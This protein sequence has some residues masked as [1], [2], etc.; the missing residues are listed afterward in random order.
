MSDTQ[1]STLPT[2]EA[3]SEL[4]SPSPGLSV[5]GQGSNGSV[6]GDA[7]LTP[8]TT[9]DSSDD[10]DAPGTPRADVKPQG[11]GE[12]DMVSLL[13]AKVKDLE[14]QAEAD[15]ENYKSMQNGP[16]GRGGPPM[17]GYPTMA[18]WDR[19]FN[20]VY[21]DPDRRERYLKQAM[22]RQS[23]EIQ[24]FDGRKKVMLGMLETELEWMKMEDES[25][26]KLI[27]DRNQLQLETRQLAAKLNE[28]EE[29]LAQLELE[30]KAAAEKNAPAVEVK[31]SDNPEDGENPKSPVAT[32]A[33]ESA[34]EEPIVTAPSEPTFIPQL[35]RVAWDAFTVAASLGIASY[36][37]QPTN[38]KISAIDVL[39]GDPVIALRYHTSYAFRG[40]H[41]LLDKKAPVPKK[42]NFARGQGPLPERIR[43]N[44]RHILK[45]LQKIDSDKFSEGDGGLVMLRPFKA[46]VY[47]EDQIRKTYQ[48][49]KKKF[50]PPSDDSPEEHGADGQKDESAE[51]PTKNKPESDEPKT[52]KAT[53]SEEEDKDP[54]TSS[55]AA[56]EQL[57]VLIDFMD[58]EIQSKFDYVR[59]EQCQRVSFNDIWYLFR[60]GDEVIDQG[61]KQVY[62]VMGVTSSAHKVIPPWRNFNA[63]VAKSDETPVMIHCVYVDFDGKLLGPVLR[64][65]QL[66]RFEGEKP[67]TSLPVY[68][69][70]LADGRRGI[71]TQTFRERLIA[72]GRMFT[73][74]LSVKHMNYN[75][76]TLDT[77]DEVDGQV[78]VDFEESFA[79]DEKDAAVE[80]KE[81]RKSKWRPQVQSLIGAEMHETEDEDCTAGCCT[82][83]RVLKDLYAEKKRNEDYINSLI[84]EELGR[85]PS[86]AIYPRALKDLKSSGD[87]LTEDELLVMSYRVF[88]FILRS[89]KWAKFDLTSLEY[90]NSGTQNTNHDNQGAS[91]P[92][93]TAFDQL[94]MERNQKNVILSLIA[95]H[96][97]DKESATAAN[98]QVDIV[99]GKGKGLIILL[100]G[101]PGVGKTTTAEGV[102]ELFARP[103]FQITCGDLGTTAESVEASLE[104][105]FSLANRWGC[106]LLLDEAD[107]F[108]AKRTPQDFKR[109]GLVSVF[110]RV[111]EYY[112]GILFLTTNRIGD[113]DEA[114]GSRIH[115]SLHYPQLTLNAT[116]EIFELNLRLVNQRF[117]D[118]KRTLKVE[119]D[120]ILASAEKYWKTHKK[121][122]WNGRQIR[123][124]CQ[125]A[126]ALAEF[127]AQ[128]GNH[129]RIIDADAVVK[130][131]VKHLETVSA[132][133][134]EFMRY[135]EKLY[136]TDQDRLAHKRG[137]RARELDGLRTGKTTNVDDKL[138][139]TS[140]EESEDAED[141]APPAPSVPAAPLSSSPVTAAPSTPALGA[142]ASPLAGL[143]PQPNINAAMAGA[144]PDQGPAMMAN[145]QAGNYM[146]SNYGYPQGFQQAFPQGGQ[147]MGAGVPNMNP[148]QQAQMWQN[149]QPTLWQQ[150]ILQG[151]MPPFVPP[152]MNPQQPGNAGAPPDVSGRPNFPPS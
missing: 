96:F 19:C 23:G 44:S 42:K 83:E 145:P 135:L 53:P 70:R 93:E 138:D 79:N 144:V 72:R 112:A 85:E 94:V 9:T 84:P 21:D 16:F 151:Q 110:L 47:Y 76:F 45:I 103:L 73:D 124:A 61:R 5:N 150:A 36:S 122:R 71:S 106:I 4:A 130:L 89:R 152:G 33:T 62:R 31:E 99:R 133:Y 57:Q 7:A 50:G 28:A 1:S 126:L 40:K 82:G 120:E 92:R 20:E 136:K 139:S 146:F 102:A 116:K 48:D 88:G 98:E 29:R 141:A 148:Q 123:N 25:L 140:G 117:A 34:P 11:Q 134:L 46:L 18:C 60:P 6:E 43:I 129:M 39:E 17:M 81:K 15:R 109:N 74:V 87:Q 90:V 142:S 91:K 147:P 80:G 127:D 78:M 26:A 55:P 67:V 12:D 30:A 52:D 51:E 27:E 137:Y 14:K 77:R 143:S 56:L 104:T 68:P 132:A 101:A 121:M 2:P 58:T 37:K 54:L 10:N 114:F 125:T 97:R 63:G 65:V 75:G 49:L 32:N 22:P 115:I 64:S 38:L 108:L 128:G 66:P 149:M 118:K 24:Y 8:A 3:G 59:S 119:K 13:M 107:V 95:Q 111:L 100:H 113:F 105:H 131:S 35:K 86:V 69:L 41:S